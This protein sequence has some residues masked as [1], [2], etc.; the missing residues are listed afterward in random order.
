[1][2]NS[3]RAKLKNPNIFV[4]ATR[5]SV[6]NLP[7]QVTDRQ[8]KTVFLKAADSKAAVI[9][10]VSSQSYLPLQKQQN[11]LLMPYKQNAGKEMCMHI[12]FFSQIA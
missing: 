6:H 8:L 4:S 3:K 1:M 2:E 5:L 10:E 11:V 9:T 12:G 7:T